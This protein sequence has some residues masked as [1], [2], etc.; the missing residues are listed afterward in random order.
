[1]NTYS[2]HKDKLLQTEVIFK[3]PLHHTLIRCMVGGLQDSL[4]PVCQTVL[5]LN[6]LK[7]PI[8]VWHG[9]EALGCFLQRVVSYPEGENVL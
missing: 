7:V 3:P 6:V 8:E 9:G 5:F 4:E 1:M 2:F